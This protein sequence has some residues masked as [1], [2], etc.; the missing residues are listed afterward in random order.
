MQSGIS[1]RTAGSSVETEQMSPKSGSIRPFYAVVLGLS[2][3]AGAL[4]FQ[5]F[6]SD[7]RTAKLELKK[8]LHAHQN[9]EE[10]ANYVLARFIEGEVPLEET[11]ETV[12]LVLGPDGWIERI[13]VSIAAPA[14]QSWEPVTMITP[15]GSGLY[16][17]EVTSVIEGITA[18]VKMSFRKENEAPDGNRVNGQEWLIISTSHRAPDGTLEPLIKGTSA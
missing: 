8:S 10:G 6:Q 11:G 2:V 1:D 7:Q 3:L 12:K 16:S 5:Q 9:A 14:G 15:H 13:P 17:F 4:A 18:T